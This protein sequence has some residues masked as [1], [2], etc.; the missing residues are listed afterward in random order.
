VIPLVPVSTGALLPAFDAHG[1]LPPKDLFPGATVQRQGAVV[2][3]ASLAEMYARYVAA[4]NSSKSRPAIWDGWMEHRRAIEALGITY[5]TL[6]NG[7]F[8]TNR[9]DPGDVDLCY[10]V[11]AADVNALTGP[12]Q[13]AFRTL[14]DVAHC[15]KTYRCDP[16]SVS[17]YPLTHFRFQTMINSITYWSNV[18]GVD[19]RGRAKSFVI[20][21]EAGVL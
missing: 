10:L 6:V 18:F 21:T 17:A 5:A 15:K 12:N 20:V 13:A 16:Y 3:P 19:R 7:S 8:I 2:L 14:F 1:N 9:L 11:D 4:Y